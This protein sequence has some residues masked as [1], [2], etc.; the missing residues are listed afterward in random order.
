MARKFAGKA[1]AAATDLMTRADVL[2]LA[3]RHVKFT[4]TTTTAF[5]INLGATQAMT[6]TVAPVTPGDVLAA[7]E[8]INAQPVAALPNG[9]NIAWAYVSA[10][11]RC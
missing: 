3:G 4:G 9:V 7:G 10:N 8:D 11:N 2:A 5:A 6:L 1:A